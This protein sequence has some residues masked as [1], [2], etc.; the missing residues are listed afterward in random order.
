MNDRDKYEYWLEAAKY[1]LE[2]AEV[3]F[4]GGRYMYVAFMSQQAIE[5]ITKGIYTLYTGKDAP[6]THNIWNLFK[7]L[8]QDADLESLLDMEEFAGELLK[9]KNF[10]VE[11]L[12][13]YISGRYPSYKER[14]SSSIDSDRAGRILANTKEAFRWIESL[15]QYKK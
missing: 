14:I 3:M 8:K 9:N 7:R 15:N 6:R 5:K 13:C 4:K 10:F 11:L 1:D 12:A 2:S